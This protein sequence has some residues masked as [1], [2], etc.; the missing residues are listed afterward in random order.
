MVEGS[1][2]AAKA[3]LID[4]K[5]ECVGE[6]YFEFDHANIDTLL[7]EVV[8]TGTDI[9]VPYFLG[10][11]QERLLTRIH[12]RGLKQKFTPVLGYFNEVLA[13][14]LSPEVRE[15]I[16]STNSYFMSADTRL[17]RRYLEKLAD[18][19]SQGTWPCGQG[20]IS[21]F[22]EGVISCLIAIVTAAHNLREHEPDILITSERLTEA[23]RHV[24][25]D[26]LQG[27][28]SMNSKFQHA[29]VNH[30]LT[31]CNRMGEFDII[32]PPK[33]ISPE[34]P[35]RHKHLENSLQ[36]NSP[37]ERS[38][39]IER[40][41]LNEAIFSAAFNSISEAMI[42]CDLEGNIVWCSEQGSIMF[43]Y[44]AHEMVGLTIED[45]IPPAIE[46]SIST[47]PRRS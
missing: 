32:T 11:E 30:Y 39:S 13:R 22:G 23:L 44:A 28:V 29:A 43:G 14:D 6:R 9:L 24:S 1:I 17:N 47:T 35:P 27:H 25:F 7:S 45:L 42:M 2:D 5:G 18:Y 40:I 41:E 8:R 21:N 38:Q 31:R 10:E 3:A 16:Y 26:S 20:V 37:R 46:P 36:E 12:E 34:L 19:N 15:G 4:A 33:P